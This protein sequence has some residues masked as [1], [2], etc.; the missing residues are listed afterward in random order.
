MHFERKDKL[1]KDLGDGENSPK[2]CFNIVILI[3]SMH[4]AIRD[5]LYEPP[6]LAHDPVLRGQTEG[7]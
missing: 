5:A 4:A 7:S 1:L 3:I 2:D 6:S